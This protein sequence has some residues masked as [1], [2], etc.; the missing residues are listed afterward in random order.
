MGNTVFQIGPGTGIYLKVVLRR[1]ELKTHCDFAAATIIK[2]TQYQENPFESIPC[3]RTK[4]EKF[5]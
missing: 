1:M 5:S 3:S 4:D 2:S